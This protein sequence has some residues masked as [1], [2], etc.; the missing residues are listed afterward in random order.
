MADPAQSTIVLDGVTLTLVDVGGDHIPPD[1]MCTTHIN[2]GWYSTAPGSPM[3][4]DAHDNPGLICSLGGKVTTFGVLLGDVRDAG[5]GSRAVKVEGASGSTRECAF[6]ESAHVEI[7]EAT[8]RSAPF[9]AMVTPDYRKVMVMRL[10]VSM[11]GCPKIS[12]SLTYVTTAADYHA[13][14]NTTCRVCSL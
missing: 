8:G 6:E 7:L 2:E 12:A 4:S 3:P 1:R 14:T 11:A 10:V 5:A 13:E 9:P